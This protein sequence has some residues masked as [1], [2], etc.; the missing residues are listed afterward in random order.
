MS[1]FGLSKFIA[2]T[3]AGLASAGNKKF[4]DIKDKRSSIYHSQSIKKLEAHLKIGR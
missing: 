4:H 2:C 3:D 1:N